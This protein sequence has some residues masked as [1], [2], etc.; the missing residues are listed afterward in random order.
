VDVKYVG[1]LQRLVSLRDLRVEAALADMSVVRRA[2]LSV[3]PA[4]EAEFHHV[5]GMGG[6]MTTTTTAAATVAAAA[7]GAADI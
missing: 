2:R 7:G 3:S 1:K 4:K 6:G 5:V